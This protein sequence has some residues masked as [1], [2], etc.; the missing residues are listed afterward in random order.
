MLIFLLLQ[1]GEDFLL[2][3]WYLEWKKNTFRW[4]EYEF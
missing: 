3:N 2:D 4:K 1:T